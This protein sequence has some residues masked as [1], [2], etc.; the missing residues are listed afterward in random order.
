MRSHAFF[1]I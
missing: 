1:D